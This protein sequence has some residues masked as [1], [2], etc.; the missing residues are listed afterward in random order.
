MLQLSNVKITGSN[1]E[2]KNHRL[3]LSGSNGFSQAQIIIFKNLRLKL[4]NA[5]KSHA[6]IIK[7][8]EKKTGSNYQRKITGSNYQMKNHRLKLSNEKN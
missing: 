7:W 4:L 6:Q 8:K 1:Y 3:K 2:M 5:K